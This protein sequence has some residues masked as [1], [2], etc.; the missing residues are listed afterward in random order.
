MGGHTW[1]PSCTC[2]TAICRDTPDVHPRLVQCWPRVVDA[3]PA[4]NQPWVNVSCFMGIC[5]E[6]WQRVKGEDHITLWKQPHSQL[7]FNLLRFARLV[8]YVGPSLYIV[9]C[10]YLYNINSLKTTIFSTRFWLAWLC[11]VWLVLC[12]LVLSYIFFNFRFV[13]SCLI[14][15]LLVLVMLDWL[16]VGWFAL[17]CLSCLVL[18]H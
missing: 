9:F 16:D 14:L 11:W 15:S 13:L 7:D 6:S 4:L 17:L 12:C 8:F 3:G 1:L 18:C 10:V 2:C 5:R